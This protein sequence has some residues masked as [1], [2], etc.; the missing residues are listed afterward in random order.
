MRDRLE[1]FGHL[2]GREDAAEKFIMSG[3]T[4]GEGQR[5]RGRPR[6]TWMNNIAKGTGMTVPE[7]HRAA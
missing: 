4:E 7:V 5:L 1:Y 3:I 2:A 6:A